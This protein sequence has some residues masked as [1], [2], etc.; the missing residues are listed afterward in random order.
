MLRNTKGHTQ[1]CEAAAKLG[2]AD[3]CHCT[4]CS[5]TIT[6]HSSCSY[7][8]ICA[9]NTQMANFVTISAGKWQYITGIMWWLNQCPCLVP[10]HSCWCVRVTL[11]TSYYQIQRQRLTVI[12]PGWRRIHR[13]VCEFLFLVKKMWQ[14]H[15]YSMLQIMEIWSEPLSKPGM[16]ISV[17]SSILSF[18]YSTFHL[19][20]PFK[21]SQI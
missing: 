13:K 10:L 4:F 20:S 12:C 18:G 5:M 15:W 1:Q 2:K 11:S 14:C 16:A 7:R 6:L 8:G 9:H 19:L 17:L 21:F 3:G